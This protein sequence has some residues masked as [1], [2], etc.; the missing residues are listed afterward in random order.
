MATLAQL[1]SRLI[2]RL[3]LTSVD[4]IIPTAELNQSIQDALY[5]FANEQTWP[6]QTSITTQALTAGTTAYNLPSGATKIHSIFV[7][8]RE[9]SAVQFPDVEKYTNQ[10]QAE[11]FQYAVEASQIH[12]APIPGTGYTAKIVYDSGENVLSTDSSTPKCPDRFVDTIVT[13][14]TIF[15]A[16]RLHKTDVLASAM[17]LLEAQMKRAQDSA[18]MTSTP[19]AVRIRS[20]FGGGYG[21]F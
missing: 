5:E 9:L 1:R 4:E 16:T 13:I 10:G 15:Q 19:A 21:A 8:G 14:A 7:N 6:W 11:P 2:A 17:K 12:F 20:D 18:I 3:G